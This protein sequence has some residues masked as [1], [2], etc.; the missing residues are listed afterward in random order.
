[1]FKTFI[2]CVFLFS[3]LAI[4]QTVMT[5]EPG[6]STSFAQILSDAQG[7]SAGWVGTSSICFS[8]RTSQIEANNSCADARETINMLSNDRV[9]FQISCTP[10]FRD[11]CTYYSASVMTVKVM[12]LP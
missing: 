7:A 2:A 5:A 9:V 3:N 10:G 12:V 1:M 11:F 4:A 6:S 8:N